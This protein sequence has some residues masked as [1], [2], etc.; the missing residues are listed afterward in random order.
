MLLNR[1]GLVFLGRR[2]SEAQT[3]QVAD[4]YAWQMPQGGIDPGESPTEAALRELHEETNVRSAEL[5][6]EAPEWY[7]YDLPSVVA[8]RAWRGRYPGAD[9]EMVRV[10]LPRARRAR[11]TS[12]TRAGA[13]PSSTRGAGSAWSACP[14]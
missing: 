3:D 14:T 1:E 5:L 2:R 13:S 4:G 12:A 7:S 10:P 11:S 8:G 6:A 9:A